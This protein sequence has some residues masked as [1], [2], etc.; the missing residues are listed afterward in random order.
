MVIVTV[1]LPPLFVAVTV[2]VVRG[3]TA[4]GVPLSSPFVVSKT[5]PDGRVGLIDQLATGSPCAVGMT[6][7]KGV[8]LVRVNEPGT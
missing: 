7:P 6:A 8:P 3:E 2:Y 5:N 1:P 4:V